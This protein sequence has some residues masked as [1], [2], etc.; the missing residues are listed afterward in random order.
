MCMYFI[1]EVKYCGFGFFF[2]GYP[3]VTLDLVTLVT[4]FKV[5][6]LPRSLFKNGISYSLSRKNKIAKFYDR[7]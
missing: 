7:I 5:I 4:H 3:T 1:A 6:S 2:S